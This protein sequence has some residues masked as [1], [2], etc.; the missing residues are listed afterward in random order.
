MIQHIVLVK[1]KPGTTEQEIVDAF[2]AS[3]ELLDD[4]DAVRKLTIGRDRAESG[5]R[6]TH[7]LIVTLAD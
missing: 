3:R 7:A 2:T 4:I 1:W 5:H 6:F